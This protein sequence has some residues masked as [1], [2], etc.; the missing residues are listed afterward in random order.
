MKKNIKNEKIAKFAKN[1]EHCGYVYANPREVGKKYV[2][3]PGEISGDQVWKGRKND[4]PSFKLLVSFTNNGYD[5]T[6]YVDVLT[7]EAYLWDAYIKQNANG[8]YLAEKM[9]VLDS[10]DFK[11]LVPAYNK[12]YLDK[13]ADTYKFW[14][15]NGTS[16]DNLD[17]VHD[18][19]SI[20]FRG[21]KNV[22][23]GVVAVNEKH[24][25]KNYEFKDGQWILK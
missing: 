19:F 22:P 12:Y 1:I 2:R 11:A 6:L 25:P 16:P 15:E 18:E 23:G 20:L 14:A 3:I 8:D 9:G 13:W 4:Y 5:E 10:E 21:M 24:L 17:G 7:G